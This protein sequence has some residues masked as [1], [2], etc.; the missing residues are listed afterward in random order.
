MSAFPAAALSTP[1]QVTV[2][3]I[4]RVLADL[5]RDIGDA[6]GEN[7][8]QVRM[9]NLLVFLPAPPPPRVRMAIN[10]VAVQYPGR[11]VAVTPDD[12]PPRVEATIACRVAEGS[13]QACGEQIMLAGSV[14]GRPLYSLAISLLLPGLPVSVWWHG[15]IDFDGPIFRRF[16]R[17]ADQFV[18]DTRT[19]SEPVAGLARLRREMA[20]HGPNVRF[21]DLLWVELVGWRR[22][23]AG[24]FDLPAGRDLL[25]RIEQV[26][27]VCGGSEASLVAALLL[28]GWLASR[29]D[30]EPVDASKGAAPGEITLRRRGRKTG[31]AEQVRLALRR[32]SREEGVSS[33]EMRASDGSACSFRSVDGGVETRVERPGH[34]PFTPAGHLRRSRLAALLGEEL[35]IT[36]TD[37]V[38][39][40]ALVLAAR[41]AE[42]VAIAE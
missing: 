18:F 15:P 21:S 35:T 29:L 12:D 42:H 8:M 14:D 7:V 32:D 41:L 38:Y 23:I 27:L 30:W 28:A 6:K 3:A 1:D 31:Q 5:W 2:E 10:A 20:V 17:V 36:M 4:E 16:A 33:L 26:V 19:W 25:A 24:A 37:R 11:T 34:A 39:G 22:S 13:Q 40:G 9:L